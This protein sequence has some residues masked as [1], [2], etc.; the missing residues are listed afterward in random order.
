MLVDEK[1]QERL[2][3]EGVV[4]YVM[5]INEPLAAAEH[6]NVFG[7]FPPH[8][9]GRIDLALRSLRRMVA[10]HDIAYAAIKEAAEKRGWKVN[11][12]IGYNWQYHTGPVGAFFRSV[13]HF[14]SDLFERDGRHTDFVGLQYYCWVNHLF[15]GKKEGISGRYL[16]WGSVYPE[17]VFSVLTDMSAR[18]EGKPI[19]ITEFGFSDAYDLCRPRWILETI[20]FARRAQ[21][22]G[23]PLEGV[24]LWTL[25]HNVEW[26][27][28]MKEHFGFCDEA[29]L[30]LL[31]P[32]YPST[33][34]ITSA[35]AFR[36]AAQFLRTPSTEAREEMQRASLRAAK[37][38]GHAL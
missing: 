3:T 10:A 21:I 17:G 15:S 14:V 36:T 4:H 20:R 24:L 31:S 38:C 33:K 22:A 23:V 5:T 28:G 16:D 30:P 18:Y 26:A 11:I 37:Q 8:R 19:W 29:E 35:E 2:L 1:T 32:R 27:R 13:D 34:E 7:I 25:A 12:C 9:K 6:G